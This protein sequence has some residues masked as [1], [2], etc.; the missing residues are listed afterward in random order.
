MRA[1]RWDPLKNQRLKKVRGVSFEEILGERLVKTTEHP[2]R[3]GQ[4]LML[5]ERRGYIWVVP[6]VEREGEIFLKTA[7][8]SRHYTKKYERG[9]L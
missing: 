5:F 1:L 3:S 8:P 7:Y 4:E 6:F 9:E 2:K